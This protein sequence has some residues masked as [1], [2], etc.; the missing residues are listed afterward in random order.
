MKYPD[1]YR[2]PTSH[3]TLIFIGMVWGP[4]YKKKI[5]FFSRYDM[6]CQDLYIIHAWQ[7]QTMEQGEKVV[8]PNH[9]KYS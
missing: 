3:Q 1:M 4:I 6:K 7:H 8:G 9:E 5:F 2:K